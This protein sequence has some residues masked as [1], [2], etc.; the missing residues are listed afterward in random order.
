VAPCVVLDG[1]C[2]RLG[3]PTRD[4]LDGVCTRG[5]CGPRRFGLGLRQAGRLAAR[6]ERGV[7]QIGC[8]DRCRG[9][10]GF[11]RAAV[12]TGAGWARV[13]QIAVGTVPGGRGLR[14]IGCGDRCRGGRG[15][16]QIGCRTVAGWAKGCG[17]GGGAGERCLQTG[18][19]GPVARR[20][21]LRW[22]H[23]VRQDRGQ[24]VLGR[25][26]AS[27]TITTAAPINVEP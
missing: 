18:C 26:C 1:D 6:G 11:G 17:T 13:R 12:G 2:G 15:L 20:A 7:G 3:G 14:Q 27:A 23:R 21:R 25:C 22:L 24:R 9:G 16:R 10:R 8:R 19:S 4:G 5:R